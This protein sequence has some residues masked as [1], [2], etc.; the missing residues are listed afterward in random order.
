[1]F[2]EAA[3][4]LLGEKALVFSLEPMCPLEIRDLDCLTEKIGAKEI[5]KRQ[6][7]NVTS[8]WVDITTAN[9]QG[10]KFT[11]ME[12]LSNMRGNS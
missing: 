3:K 6:C 7:P 12:V 2:C 4:G 10:R 5:A 9:Y 1:M 11:V 8:I